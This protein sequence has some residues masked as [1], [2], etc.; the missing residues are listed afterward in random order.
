MMRSTTAQ[1]VRKAMMR[2]WPWPLGQVTFSVNA[3]YEPAEAL[4]LFSGENIYFRSF[5]PCYGKYIEVYLIV[6]PYRLNIINN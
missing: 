3:E 1:S 2:I 6:V 5:I 4:K